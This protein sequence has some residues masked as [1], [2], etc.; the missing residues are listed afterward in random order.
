MSTLLVTLSYPAATAATGYDYV[1]SADG[2][3]VSAQGHVPAALLPASPGR[4]NAVVAVVPARAMSWHQVTLPGTMARALRGRLAGQPRLRAVLAGLLEELLLDEPDQLHFAVFPGAT[5]D[6]PVWV[7]VCQRAWLTEALHA[8]E[9]LPQRILRIVPEFAP[10][11]G[12]DSVPTADVTADGAAAQLVLRTAQG[13]T[14]LPLGA[15]AAA[16]VQRAGSVEIFAEPDVA[17]LA[18]QI[19]ERPV[20]E[21]TRGQRL[22][23]TLHSPWNLAQFE[24]SATR[25]SR[26]LR[27]LALVGASLLQAPQWRPLRWGLA[28][29]LLV[30]V[31]GLNVLAWKEQSLL[32]EKRERMNALFTRALPDVSVVVDPPRQME[33]AVALLQEEAGLGNGPGLVD[34]FTTIAEAAP[35][36]TPPTTIEL[37]DGELRLQGPPPPPE[38][39]A[40]LSSRLAVQGWRARAQ[41]DLLV[42]QPQGQP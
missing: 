23:H 1:L 18:G 3:S 20:R 25:R 19:L 22:L 30:Q 16:W 10:L 27:E 14:L 42:I 28:L 38:L 34:L 13:V 32:E 21:Q 41:G 31:L 26:V 40:T 6:A 33:R 37:S 29:L 4:G 39:V 2:S 35:G 36:Y 11:Q 5:R 12:G 8:L 24:L 17:V 7:A 15:A 9:V